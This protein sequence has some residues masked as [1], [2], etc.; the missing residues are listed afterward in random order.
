MATACRPTPC[1]PPPSLAQVLSAITKGSSRQTLLYLS[2]C[3][4][5]AR[6]ADHVGR[7]A[8]H[9]AASCGQTDVVR[10]LVEQRQADVDRRDDESGWTP[11]HRALYHGQITTAQTLISVSNHCT[12]LGLHS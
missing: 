9:V 4:N 10:W 6:L 5:V 12:R 3:P 8:L 7:T 1:E 11:L 2:R